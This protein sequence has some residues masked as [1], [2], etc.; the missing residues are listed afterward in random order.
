[1]EP[2]FCTLCIFFVLCG[3][4]FTTNGS[5]GLHE[6]HKE[7]FYPCTFFGLLRILSV[8]EGPCLWGRYLQ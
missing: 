6:G 5:K 3:Y 7:E 2:S 1:M 4:F 8:V